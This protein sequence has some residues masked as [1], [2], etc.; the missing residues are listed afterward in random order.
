MIPGLYIPPPQVSSANAMASA[1]PSLVQRT[2]YVPSRDLDS[3]VNPVDQV[4]KEYL[5]HLV[6]IWR[7]IEAATGYQWRATS[8]LRK[9]PSHKYGVSLDITPNYLAQLP[10]SSDPV[11]NRR[12][13]LLL[14][15]RRLVN[16]PR[17]IANYDVIIAVESDHIHI[18]LCPFGSLPSP[19]RL[20][21]WKMPKPLY[22]DTDER[23]T[24]YLPGQGVRAMW[25]LDGNRIGDAA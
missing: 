9:S 5:P 16:Q 3:I 20:I 6:Q 19:N 24:G 25:D 14:D 7:E 21:Q 23:Q 17:L 22:S 1:T 2:E 10:P 4:I 8:Y 12:I 18:Q 11:L 15:L 13:P